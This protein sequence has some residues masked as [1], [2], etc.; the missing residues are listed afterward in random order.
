MLTCN[1]FSQFSGEG[2]CYYECWKCFTAPPGC[3][4]EI[5][6]SCKESCLEKIKAAFIMVEAKKGHQLH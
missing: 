2:N 6:A 1:I 5:V 4:A 3:E